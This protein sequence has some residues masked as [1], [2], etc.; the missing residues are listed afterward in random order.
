MLHFATAINAQLLTEQYLPD[1]GEVRRKRI[2]FSMR[3][4]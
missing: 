4:G 2:T 1:H 3:E